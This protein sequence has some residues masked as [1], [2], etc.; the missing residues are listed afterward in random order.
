M[1]NDPMPTTTRAAIEHAAEEL[2][3]G[4]FETW[5]NCPTHRIARM[6]RTSDTL[7]A[8]CPHCYSVFGPNGEI[9]NPIP[10]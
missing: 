7:E 5:M 2:G 8:Y 4:R 10:R 9:L 3:S 1:R 6:P